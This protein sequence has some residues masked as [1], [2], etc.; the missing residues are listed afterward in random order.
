MFWRGPQSTISRS[1]SQVIGTTRNTLWCVIHPIAVPA[2]SHG[3]AGTQSL[4]LVVGDVTLPHF[5]SFYVKNML[6]RLRRWSRSV[7]RRNREKSRHAS[8]DP[9]DCHSQQAV[10]LSDNENLTAPSQNDSL[11]P[12]LTS[13]EKRTGSV[14]VM[15]PGTSKDE[16]ATGSRRPSSSDV[17]KPNST[18]S[19]VISSGI[20]S[21]T[22]SKKTNGSI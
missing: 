20:G 22:A 18:S 5:T 12:K 19:V 13:K 16:G 15:P 2:A 1:F 8:K 6:Q 4:E 17:D 9:G 11:S 14:Q 10:R 21:I 3:A 7:I